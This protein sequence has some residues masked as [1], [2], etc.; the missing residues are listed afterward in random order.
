MVNS[1]CCEYGRFMLLEEISL[2]FEIKV[3]GTSY[4]YK[5]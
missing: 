5:L 4:K 2:G 3:C 1:E